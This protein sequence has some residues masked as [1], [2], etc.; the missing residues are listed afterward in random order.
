MEL[1]TLH[2]NLTQKEQ[3][4]LKLC[5]L[6]LYLLVQENTDRKQFKGERSL[7]WLRS[8]GYISTV[9]EKSRQELVM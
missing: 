4:A 7:F 6:V 1:I 9:V 3:H 2:D 5:L 8:P